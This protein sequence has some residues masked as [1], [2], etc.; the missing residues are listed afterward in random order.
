MTLP[1]PEPDN[2]LIIPPVWDRPYED[3]GRDFRFGAV[4]A[5]L[6]VAMF[7]S[8]VVW[9]IG[10]R[11][12][13]DTQFLQ[14]GIYFV[15]IPGTMA[16]LLA[17]IRPKSGAMGVSQGTTIAVLASA[18]VVREGFI[19][20]LLAL[21]LIIPVVAIVA[22]I[23]RKSKEERSQPRFAVVPLLLLAMSGEGVAY[24]LPTGAVAREQ[25]TMNVSANQLEQ[26]LSLAPEIPS[27]EPLLFALPFPKPVSVEVTGY[28]VGDRQIVAFDSGG[29]L[30]LEITDRQPGR[31]EWAI[32]GNTTPVAGWMTLNTV[33]AS[34]TGTGDSVELDVAI[35]FD[36]EL[37]PAIYFDPLERWGVGELA[38]VLGDM[39]E[40]NAG[41]V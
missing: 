14:T 39:L 5:I 17:M 32:V 36:R 28:A 20:V 40:H 6:L 19:C 30:T 22:W 8:I 23:A 41:R 11:R 29:E 4:P 25:R 21:P 31:I 38:E 15:A 37:N 27:I 13:G 7:A 18:I 16:I 9:V 3:G 35:D 1:P 12:T 24:E 34:W 2:D 33:E 10:D 26:S